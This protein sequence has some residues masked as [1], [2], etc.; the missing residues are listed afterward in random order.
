MARRDFIV[1]DENA[2]DLEMLDA[3]ARSDQQGL[4]IS[5]APSSGKTHLATIL[6]HEL[7]GDIFPVGLDG[8]IDHAAD[9]SL[10]IIDELERLSRP[11]LMLECMAQARERG[12]RFV[13]VGRGA[14]SDWACGLRDL[15]TRLEALPRIHTAPPDEHLLRQVM[16]KLFQERQIKVH[17]RVIEYAAPRLERSLEAAARFVAAADKVAF[18]DAAAVTV[19]LAKQ[20]IENGLIGEPTA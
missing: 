19:P 11:K 4:A 14:P 15:V 18:A 20:I 6:A 9:Q 16:A 7:G 12:A 1:T 13:F 10:F 5:G 8:G 2:S 17:P 3:W